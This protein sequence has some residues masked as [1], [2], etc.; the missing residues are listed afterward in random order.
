MNFVWMQALLASYERLLE[1]FE[2]KN[3]GTDGKIQKK[4]EEKNIHPSYGTEKVLHNISFEL[5]KG[6][7]LS[8]IEEGPFR[9]KYF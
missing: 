8:N 2:E 9:E 3:D 5:E 4:I 1:I 6:E 7:I